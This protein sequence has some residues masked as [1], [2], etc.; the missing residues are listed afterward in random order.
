MGTA[1]WEA[2]VGV[3]L[4]ATAGARSLGEN[5]EGVDAGEVREHHLEERRKI[6]G[7]V[8]WQG[9]ELLPSQLEIL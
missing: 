7:L 2:P 5:E 8:Y 9:H 1:I 6:F 3:Q 4:L